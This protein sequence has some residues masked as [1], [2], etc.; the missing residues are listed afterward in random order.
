MGISG[1]PFES[2]TACA[3]LFAVGVSL[4]MSLKLLYGARGPRSDDQI[5]QILNV[6]GWGFILLPAAVFIA[7]STSFIGILLGA[8]FFSTL[9][10]VVLVRREVQRQ[11]VWALLSA[12]SGRSPESLRRHQSRFSGIVGRAFRHLVDSL[13]SG[14]SIPAAIAANPAALPREAQAFAAISASNTTVRPAP[15]AP[16]YLN[17]S[18]LGLGAHPDWQVL[19]KR[20]AYVITIVIAMSLIMSFVM[21]KI[22]PSFHAIFEDFGLELPRL[23]VFLISGAQLFVESHAAALLV[24]S[25]CMLILGLIAI[26]IAYLCDLPVLRPLTDRL[27]MGFH[28]GLVLRLLAIAADRGNPFTEVLHQ[29]VHESPRYPSRHVRKRI[30]RANRLM[31]GGMNWKEALVA[32]SFVKRADLPL[33]ATAERA[34]NLSWVLQFLAERKTRMLFFRWKAFEQFA[35]PIVI[36]LIGIT[37][38]FFCVALFI[39]LVDLI[40]SL[41]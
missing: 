5:F 28:R 21:I 13:E 27:F 41:C 19:T 12:N 11:A 17:A 25:T 34:G 29:L 30:D 22:V 16:A 9:I 6:L 23:T 20:I 32:A 4:R 40:K 35:F 3:I 14:I 33:L 18:S 2:L 36:V 1:I 31:I 8:I 39:P 24:L 37:T 10:E 26:S 7:M 38:G 15:P